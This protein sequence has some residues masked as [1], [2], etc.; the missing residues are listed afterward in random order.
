MTG[1][2]YQ[3]WV[4]PSAQPAV[5]P[6]LATAAGV[7]AETF[8]RWLI[9]DTNWLALS[10]GLP[11]VTAIS[12]PA[13]QLVSEIGFITGSVATSAQSHHWHGLLDPAGNLVAASADDPAP[14]MDAYA[15]IPMDVAVP[16]RVPVSGTYWLSCCVSGPESPVLQGFGVPAG[17]GVVFW[18]SGAPVISGLLG[19]FLSPPLVPPALGA[20]LG[21]PMSNCGPAVAYG[22]VR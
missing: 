21:V 14:T 2:P 5:S 17:N 22:W 16:Y 8:P 13:G 20:A 18:G 3:P 7:V 12:L 4:M 11:V 9:N 6:V 19:P 1:V 10:D 15:E